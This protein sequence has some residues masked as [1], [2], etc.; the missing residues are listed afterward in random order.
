[1][2]GAGGAK[3]GN[4]WIMRAYPYPEGELATIREQILPEEVR[5]NQ[6][7]EENNTRLIRGGVAKKITDLK[8]FPVDEQTTF[9]AVRFDFGR[10][11]K[12]TEP[13]QVEVSVIGR[14]G[15]IAT[16]G[17]RSNKEG[18]EAEM[19]PEKAFSEEEIALVAGMIDELDLAKAT[20]EL[21]H[22]A[23]SLHRLVVACPSYTEYEKAKAV[24]A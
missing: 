5:F 18:D 13:I 21:P 14:L 3:Y 6:M 11:P 24:P 12:G 10:L 20:G 23:D 15:F 1:M 22:L 16:I 8:M 7:L 9:Q 17:S 2:A 4:V 19:L